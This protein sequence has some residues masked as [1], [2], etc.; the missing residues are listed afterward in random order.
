MKKEPR[1]AL[2][3][4]SKDDIKRR[5]KDWKISFGTATTPFGTALIAEAPR[6]ICRLTFLDGDDN[7]QIDAM[8]KDWPAAQWVRND[9][10]AKQTAARI[11]FNTA[12][13][14]SEPVAVFLAGT[15][16][17][18]RVWRTLLTLP[19]GKLAT[20]GSLAKALKNP[21]ASRAVGGALGK[22]RVAF[23]I[24]CHRV[25]RESGALGGYRWGLERKQAMLARET[26]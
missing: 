23:L 18:N 1:I 13:A 4:A 24:P 3:I 6:G 26:V 5:G 17:Q 20:Y 11:F 12:D 2:S 9:K 19:E 14:P 10:R 22:N 16:F 15:E 21:L 25:I 8:T 7:E